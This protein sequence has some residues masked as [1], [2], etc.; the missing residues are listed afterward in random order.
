MSEF[1][2]LSLNKELSTL[3]LESPEENT[4]IVRLNRP[5]AGNSITTEMGEEIISVFGALEANPQSFRTV[6]LTG[7]G[8]RIFCGGADLK[9]RDGMTDEDFNSQ[10][11]LFE[12]MI[13][14]IYDCPMPLIASLN[15]SAV[16]GGLELALACDFIV[17][18]DEA[19]FGFLEVKRGIMPGGGGTQTLPRAI[20]TRRAKELI[21]SADLITANQALEWGLVNHLYPKDEVLNESI[22]LARKINEN[23]PLAVRQAKKSIHFGTQMDTRTA[24][25][26]E[27]EVYS[28]V[29]GTADRLEG[30]KAFVEKRKPAF[31]GS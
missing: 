30:I 28:R 7:T 31:V 21:F 9:Q 26:F 3:V 8:D 6:L 10:H 15:G 17:S 20:G 14:S 5:K 2:L 12:R 13:R 16:A 29:V 23:A 22:S 24:L 25:F 4:L 19:K 27:A 18:S 1:D 11:Y